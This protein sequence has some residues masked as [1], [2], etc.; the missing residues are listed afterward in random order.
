MFRL[1]LAVYRKNRTTTMRAYPWSFVMARISGAIFSLAVPLIL[2]YLVFE[3]R[4]SDGFMEYTNNSNYI[5]FIA[6]GAI[7]NVLSFSTLMNV[8]RCLITEQRE[9][10][11]DNFLLSPASRHGYYIGVYMEQFVRSLFEAFFVAVFSFAF[12]FRINIIDFPIILLCIVLSSVTF[13]SVS[14]LIST[15]MIY[16]RDTYLVQNTM[17]LVMS[18]LCG[19][20]FPVEYL[21]KTLRIISR[22]IPMTYTLKITRECSEGT[23]SSR[24][25]GTDILILIILSIVY[26]VLGYCGFRKLEKKL[27]EDV[28]S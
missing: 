24:K 17:F 3:E 10:T 26:Y 22:I 16:T 27:I 14:I 28:L 4:L 25:Y 6:I 13:F 11:L 12:G 18:C 8:G 5:N 20:A 7:I 19:V 21:P 9:G 2:Y 15:I 1:A 23:F